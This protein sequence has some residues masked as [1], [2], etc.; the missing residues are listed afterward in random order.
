MHLLPTSLAKN[1]F[2]K[3]LSGLRAG[4][5]ELISGADTWEFG[6]RESTLRATVVVHNE[7]FFRR[8]VLGGDVAIGEAWMDGDWSSPDLVSVV[9][10]A[11]RNVAQLDSSNRWLS[12]LGRWS[13]RL[14]HRTRGNTE[15]GSRRNIQAHY[16]LSNDFFRLFLDPSMMYS[17]AYFEG[18]DESLERAQDNK[19]DRICRKLGLGPDD[20]VVEIGTGWGG[21]AEHAVRNY[22]CRVTTTT[23]SQEQ[24][25]FAKARFE[26]GGVE[27]RVTLLMEDYRK[28]RGRFS[29]LVSIEMFEAVGLEYYDTFFGTCERLLEPDGAMLLQTITMNE[30]TFPSYH[31]SADW[32]QKHIF[33]G[34]ELASVGEIL[35]SLTRV[36][37]LAIQHVEDIGLHYSKTL[38]A[39]RA[40]F[41][42]AVDMV[43]DMGFDERFVRKWDYYFAYCEAAFE[44]RHIGDLQMVLAKGAA[45]GL[46]GM[47]ATAVNFA[48]EP[49]R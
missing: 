28:L 40:R 7:R 18:G 27:D 45:R 6:D 17:C 22:G 34:S 29:K 25:D 16:D 21:F 1:L 46:I 23:I 30:R 33:P 32:I 42:D 38:A 2:L 31:G 4:W 9:R 15:T 47:P 13:D 14:L 3:S 19:L 39:W 49:A 44:E 12:A 37:R 41:H 10:V 48:S 24:H 20:H 8:A 35:K 26:A 36:T 5:L 43:R 11:V